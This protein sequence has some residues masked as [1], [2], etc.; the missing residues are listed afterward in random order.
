LEARAG[1]VPVVVVPP[2]DDL[3]APRAHLPSEGRRRSA[4]SAVK[5]WL[6]ASEGALWGLCSNGMQLRLV[7]D[8]ASLTSPAF[9]QADLRRISEGEAFAD[10]AALWL[11][12][13]TS[14]FGMPGMAPTD[15]ALEH[16][17]EAGGK[18]GIAACERL[19]DGVEATLPSLGGGFVGHP[20]NAAL[21]ERLASGALPL[22]EYFG[23]LL[24]LVYRLIFLLAAEDR[25]LLHPP[26]APAGSRKLYAEGYSVGGLRDHAVR[27]AAWDRHYDRREALLIAFSALARGEN[28]TSARRG[29]RARDDPRVGGCPPRQ[30]RSDGG[31]LPARLAEGAV[32]PRH[33][34][35]ETEELGSVYE[36]LLEL[37]PRLTADGRG[38]AFAEVGEARSN[39]RKTSGSYYTPDSLVQALL[40][41]SS[42][43]SSTASRRRPMTRLRPCLG[44]RWS[45]RP[46]VPAISCW[47]RRGASR[48]G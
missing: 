9:I 24:R 31:D 42:T 22:P 39:A 3:D 17:R 19:R 20:N 27:R 36:G 4:A 16:W 38:F 23:Q 6:N 18:E 14:R 32:R 2:S 7:R 21:R 10:F 47:P 29:V 37:T 46:A 12:I 25:N 44:R 11:L 1:R 13:H 26:T 34:Q 15:C 40:D 5:D 8:N 28:H 45:T 35:L 30:P 48:R 43:P 41:R 33:G